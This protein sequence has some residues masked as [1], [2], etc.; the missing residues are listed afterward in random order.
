[1]TVTSHSLVGML[2]AGKI[3]NPYISVPLSLVSHFAIDYIPHWDSGCNWRKKSRARLILESI[4]DFSL[5]IGLSLAIFIYF[6]HKEDYANL[7]LCILAAQLP[8]WFVVPSLLYNLN[9]PPF[10]WI[11]AIQK[12]FHNKAKNILNGTFSQIVTVVAIYLVFYR[13]F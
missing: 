12:K 1:M 9:F 5:G 2:I 7:F 11:K 8:D 13:I 4:L 3:P 6:L 10:S